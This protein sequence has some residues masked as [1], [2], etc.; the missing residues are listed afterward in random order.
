MGGMIHVRAML[1][2]IALAVGP[3]LAEDQ[4]NAGSVIWAC[5]ITFTLLVAAGIGVA[6]VPATLQNL[7]R[8]GLVYKP[9]SGAPSKLEL[10]VAWRRDDLSPLLA[11]FLAVV[12][13]IT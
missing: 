3:S 6:L 1:I 13:E 10:A 2:G 12:R 9:V 11:A 4:A 5:V 7:S 8:K